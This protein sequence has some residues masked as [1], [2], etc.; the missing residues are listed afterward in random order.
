MGT[1]LPVHTAACWLRASRSLTSHAQRRSNARRGAARFGSR[2]RWLFGDQCP[3]GLSS[4][5]STFQL[6]SFICIEVPQCWALVPEIHISLGFFSF[7]W[8]EGGDLRCNVHNAT[9]SMQPKQKDLQLQ[10]NVNMVDHYSSL[11]L[12]YRALTRSP[13][14]SVARSNSLCLSL[15]LRCGWKLHLLCSQWAGAGYLPSSSSLP[16]SLSLLFSL[17]SSLD[18]SLSLFL[19][20]ISLAGTEWRTR[21]G[22]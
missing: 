14:A 21:A 16:C 22:L 8:R 19:C 13:E 10:I 5:L 20:K 17:S 4:A 11:I 18:G 2:D 3:A 6:H 9:Y 7:P 15:S 1:G 12:S